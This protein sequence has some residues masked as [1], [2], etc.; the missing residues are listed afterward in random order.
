METTTVY[1]GYIG[2]MEKKIETTTDG[3]M[4]MKVQQDSHFSRPHDTTPQRIL[5]SLET[6]KSLQVILC[7]I[8][9][10]RNL[11]ARRTKK[12]RPKSVQE[13]LPRKETGWCFSR[14]LKLLTE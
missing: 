5:P 3:L 1:W 9:R 14:H 11:T 4:T 12:V 2:I 8:L 10:I 13:M 6:K 7:E